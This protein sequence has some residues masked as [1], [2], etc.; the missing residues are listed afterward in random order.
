VRRAFTLIEMMLVVLLIGALAG[1]AA[2]SFVRPLRAARLRA[3]IEQIRAFDATARQVARRSGREVEIVIDPY[4][5]QLVR[6]EEGRDISIF[7]LPDG[8]R[9][10]HVRTSG[11]ARQG[12]ELTLAIS[13][14]GWSRSYAVRLVGH[15]F[16]RWLLVAGMSGQVTVIE[17]ESHV[18]DILSRAASAAAARR[19]AD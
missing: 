3:T 5:R 4:Y 6:R 8:L 12:S 19:D 15:E 14:H 1:A 11:E 17:D 18:Q 7:R 13:P 2:M 9:I 16:D 10:E